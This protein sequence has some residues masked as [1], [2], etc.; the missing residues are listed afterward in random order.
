MVRRVARQRVAS[1]L[2]AQIR[3]C[4]AGFVDVVSL[5]GNVIAEH[6]ACIRHDAGGPGNDARPA[7]RVHGVVLMKPRAIFLN[8]WRGAIVRDPPLAVY[9]F[10]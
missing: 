3:P 4:F 2:H 9:P 7:L 1:D 6:R 8:G 5:A 10:D